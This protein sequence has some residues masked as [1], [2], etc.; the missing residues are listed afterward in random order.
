MKD[1]L[2]KK[3]NPLNF[4]NQNFLSKFKSQIVGQKFINIPTK[5]PKSFALCFFAKHPSMPFQ[6][7]CTK[8]PLNIPKK[9]I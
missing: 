9:Y 2:Q 8:I 7:K 5:S 6:K 1:I 4:Q 3:I